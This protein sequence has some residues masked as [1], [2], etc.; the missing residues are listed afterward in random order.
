MKIRN[1]ESLIYALSIGALM[2]FVV[3]MAF[4]TKYVKKYDDG[5]IKQSG[6]VYNILNKLSIPVNNN[7]VKIIRP[8]KDNNIKKVKE[9][10]D[11]LKE[12]NEQENAIIFFQ[13]TYIQ[14]NGIAYSNGEKF[15]VISVLDGEILEVKEDEFLGN[16]VTIKHEGMT[17]VYQSLSEVNVKEKDLV[18]QGTIIGKAGTSNI[19]ADLDNH[20]YFEMIIGDKYVNPEDYYDKEL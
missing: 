7:S 17:S 1:K 5:V 2:L 4:F 8:F 20:L 10:Y 9:F 11:Y 13:D 14:S 3:L 18:S 19:N 16:T 12:E 6:Y 15:D